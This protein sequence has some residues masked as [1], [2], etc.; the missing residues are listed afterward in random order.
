MTIDLDLLK[1][2]RETV[3][4]FI[5]KYKNVDDFDTKNKLSIIADQISKIASNKAAYLATLKNNLNNNTEYIDVPPITKA[6]SIA[7][8]DT[9]ELS[10][11]LDEFKFE[12]VKV[13]FSLK[14][15]LEKLT[16]LK[17]IKIIELKEMI[18]KDILTSIETEKIISELES[19]EKEWIDLGNKIDEI[20]KKQ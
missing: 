2:I 15:G 12:T 19:F 6:L 17:Q 7:E 10:K 14:H 9:E 8:K 1:A 5:E 3:D 16:N 4:W 18:S 11:L 20:I 13:T